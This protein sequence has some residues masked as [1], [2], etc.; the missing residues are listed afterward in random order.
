[1]RHLGATV[2]L[3]R[4]RR[5]VDH[6]RYG[7]LRSVCSVPF[8][9]H[10]DPNHIS[11]ARVW[12]PGSSRM[13]LSKLC[14]KETCLRRH[15]RSKSSRPQPMKSTSTSHHSGYLWRTLAIFWV[16]NECLQNVPNLLT[17]GSPIGHRPRKLVVDKPTLV[18]RGRAERSE[19]RSHISPEGMAISSK[20]CV[21]FPSP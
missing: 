3:L 15:A 2:R 4:L 16:G 7:K 6:D 13:T 1:M 11:N 19:E 8:L 14:D 18:I 12:S 21:S 9:R 5:N 17:Q 10:L 20:P